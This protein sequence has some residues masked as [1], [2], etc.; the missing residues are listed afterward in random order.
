M[1]ADEKAIGYDCFISD[2]PELLNKTESEPG[3]KGNTEKGSFFLAEDIGIFSEAKKGLQHS[4][5]QLNN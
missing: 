1:T 4:L 2:L 3:T 5:H